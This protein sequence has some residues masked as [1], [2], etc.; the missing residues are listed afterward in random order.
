MM[1]I[2]LFTEEE[3]R[4]ALTFEEFERIIRKGFNAQKAL[5]ATLE[6]SGV[7]LPDERSAHGSSRNLRDDSGKSREEDVSRT[8]RDESG[9]NKSTGHRKSNG[10]SGDQC[11]VCGNMTTME[12][13]E[14]QFDKLQCLFW[15]HKCAN[16]IRG[17]IPFTET[18]LDW[19][20]FTLTGKSALSGNRGERPPREEAKLGNKRDRDGNDR[21][22][23]TYGPENRLKNSVKELPPVVVEPDNKRRMDNYR[24]GVNWES[25]DRS[26]SH[27]SD[28]RSRS[29][30]TQSER[31]VDHLGRHKR[32]RRY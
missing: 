4:W 12:G 18:Q 25:Q 29:R 28:S 32:G 11:V 19:R 10:I 8:R 7:V 2:R 3:S 26:R 5:F 22:K 6:L 14:M 23:S 16:K 1:V 30:S 17:S 24:E 13:H 9:R 27:D 20:W 31:S 15:Y 21:R